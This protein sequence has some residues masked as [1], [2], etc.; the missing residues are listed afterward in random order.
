MNITEK[1]FNP[2]NDQPA[3]RHGIPKTRK[4]WGQLV[5]FETAAV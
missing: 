5:F 4:K 1:P 2:L 3:T